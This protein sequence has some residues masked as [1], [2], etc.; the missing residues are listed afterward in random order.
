[1]RGRGTIHVSAVSALEGPWRILALAGSATI[2]FDYG[3]NFCLFVECGS[4]PA[5]IVACANVFCGFSLFRC[6]QRLM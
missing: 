1:M 3:T 5:G 4:T 6:R 2:E